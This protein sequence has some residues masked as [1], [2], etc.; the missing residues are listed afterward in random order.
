MFAMV[1][2]DAAPIPTE[3]I[4]AYEL[5]I[6][7]DLLTS[8][9]QL[10]AAVF[11]YEYEDQQVRTFALGGLSRLGSVPESRLRGA[12]SR[13]EL[14]RYLAIAAQCRPDLARHRIHRFPERDISEPRPAPAGGNFY[15]ASGQQVA[16]GSC[17]DT[18]RPEL[19][20][21]TTEGNEMQRAPDYTATLGAR[22]TWSIAS[23]EMGL[24]ASAVHND[25]FYWAVDNRVEQ[26]AYTLV[27]AQ[28]DWT[29]TSRHYRLYVFGKNLT[30]EEYSQAVTS[31]TFGDIVT[32]GAA[33]DLRTGN[34]AA[35]RVMRWSAAGHRGASARSVATIRL[36]HFLV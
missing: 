35:L 32:R 24:S 27:N 21:R 5:G 10:D 29:S 2:P 18:V 13:A 11:W 25:G 6:K 36:E 22:Y 33:K 15:C 28:I 19:A 12:E 14:G 26:D 30:D 3:V 7:S 16:S 17:P 4:D 9:L 23:G 34:G 31:D 20:A 1:D 8:R